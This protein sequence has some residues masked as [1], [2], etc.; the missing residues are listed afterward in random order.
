MLLARIIVFSLLATAALAAGPSPSAAPG[1]E[2]PDTP[3]G[4]GQNPEPVRA[5]R[6]ADFLKLS[7]AR[8]KQF[9]AQRR[10]LKPVL[11]SNDEL[12][13]RFKEL[14]GRARDE[15]GTSWETA[16][17]EPAMAKAVSSATSSDPVEYFRLHAL[18]AAAYDQYVA[19]QD[20]A[21]LEDP[22][23]KAELA[24]ARGA[25]VSARSTPAEKEQARAKVAQAED[26][27]R[28]VSALMITGF[29]RSLMTLLGRYE[30]ELQAALEEVEDEG[31]A[32]TEPGERE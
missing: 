32:P 28:K 14:A 26:T 3:L 5:Y 15:A 4:T 10:A 6:A 2:V 31:L 27:R 19:S 21:V 20:L 18:V 22:K 11:A 13:E 25:A 9:I 30:K 7:E 1:D 29:P 16:A 17:R 8:L 12:G 23:A 24:A